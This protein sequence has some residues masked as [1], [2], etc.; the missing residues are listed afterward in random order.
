[1]IIWLLFL[2]IPLIIIGTIGT[3]MIFQKH[4]YMMKVIVIDSV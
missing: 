2:M 3:I 1:M 4:L